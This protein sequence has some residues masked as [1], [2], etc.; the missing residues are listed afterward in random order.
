MN[1]LRAA[2]LLVRLYTFLVLLKYRMSINACIFSGLAFIL[3]WLT[4]NP[5]NFPETTPNAHL[6]GFNFIRYILRI[7]NVSVKWATWSM[8]L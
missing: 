6:R 1:L 2:T 8:Q 5:R 4:I 7:L 3:G